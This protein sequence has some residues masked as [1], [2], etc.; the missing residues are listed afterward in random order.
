MI[1]VCFVAESLLKGSKATFESAI[2]TVPTAELFRGG[3]RPF[4]GG[5]A[6]LASAIADFDRKH[7]MAIARTLLALKL[8]RSVSRRTRLVYDLV[9]II[10]CQ[11]AI[12]GF[13]EYRTKRYLEILVLAGTCSFGT[14]TLRESDLDSAWSNLPVPQNTAA[15]LRRFAPTARN[16]ML[17]RQA[18]RLLARILRHMGSNVTLCKLS[19]LVCFERKESSGVMSLAASGD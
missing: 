10:T 8:T 2:A 18:L 6:Q 14:I 7:G 16:A 19:A 11:D 15:G 13:A 12:V 1:V 5:R 3:Q 4:G 17:Q 9:E